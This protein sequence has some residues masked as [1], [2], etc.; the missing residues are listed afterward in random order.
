[1][2]NP[3]EPNSEEKIGFDIQYFRDKTF[4]DLIKTF[5]L[6][7]K[8]GK[9]IYGDKGLLK[10]SGYEDLDDVVG[11]DISELIEKYKEKIFPNIKSEGSWFDEITIKKADGSDYKC[12]CFAKLIEESETPLEVSILIPNLD[13]IDETL[14][15]L[16]ESK[17]TYEN[18]CSTYE[19]IYQTTLTLGKKKDLEDIIKTIADEA[20]NLMDAE[21]CTVYLAN[22]EEKILEPFY[23]ND[24]RYEEQI[25]NYDIPFG[26]GEAGSVA[27]T[28]KARYLN[29]DDSRD[30]LVTIPGTKDGYTVEESIMTVP[31]FKED[32]VI[33]ILSLSKMNYRF[34]DNDLKRLKT[35][36]RQA[37]IAVRRANELRDLEDSKDKVSNEKQKIEALHKV[38]IELERCDSEDEIYDIAM[39]AAKNILDFYICTIVIYENGKLIVKESVDDDIKIGEEL[40]IDEGIYGKTYREQRSFLIDDLSKE[41]SAKPTKTEFKSILSVPIGEYG[42]FQTLSNEISFFDHDDLEITEI[43]ISHVKGAINRLRNRTVIEKR[44]EKLE[45]LHDVAVRLESCSSQ[46]EAYDVIISASEKILNFD[47]SR[48]HIAE[49]DKLVVKDIS[50][51]VAEKEENKTISLDEGIAGKTYL[52]NQSYL[53]KNFHREKEAVPFLNDYQSGLSIPIGRFGV[54][55]A[56]SYD[57]DDF[58]QEDLELG[59]L[60]ISHLTESL[61]RIRSEKR[62]SFLLTLLRH[63]LKN[64]SQIV[65]GYLQILLDIADNDEQKRFIDN[66]MKANVESQELLSKIGILKD[67]EKEKEMREI[68]VDYMI[69]NSINDQKDIAW[70]K[71]IRIE[72]NRSDKKVMGGSLLEELFSNLIENAI[73]HANCGLIRVSVKDE[74]D[75]I[76]VIVEDDGVGLSDDIKNKVLKRGFKGRKSEGLGIGTFLVKS[77]A[78]MY[79]GYVEVRDSE[80]GGARFDIVLRKA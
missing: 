5:L 58:D 28:G 77:I 55:Q 72:F 40:S 26:E 2:D 16:I 51:K 12:R 44:K 10:I 38:V 33:G 41:E 75:M 11:K 68:P 79:K 4:T 67:I 14:K 71:G 45:A 25:M 76:R 49:G 69:N 21:D 57:S 27:E 20:K 7:G 53:V 62:E 34:D 63:D 18:I 13:V 1:M 24:P 3:I 66:A 17:E 6:I 64:K 65:R 54:F 8:D 80:L 23:T 22:H 47:M 29:I 59:E 61:N 78:E 39:D 32:Q 30:H 50:S 48:I 19:N 46:K 36:A 74:D 60:L 43:L 56:V 35:F 31:L 73:N 42:V 37:E 70:D 9:V 15:E 52:N